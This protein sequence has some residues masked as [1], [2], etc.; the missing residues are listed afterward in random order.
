MVDSQRLVHVPRWVR[1]AALTLLIGTLA[2][3]VVLTLH[4]VKIDDPANPKFTDWVLVGMSLVH[5]TL[6]GLA[7]A[8]VLFY[9]EREVDADTLSVRTDT[10]LSSSVPKALAR[11]SADYALRSQRSTVTRL[12]PSDIFGAAYEIASGPHRLRA[13]IG[14]NVSRLFVIVWIAVPDAEADAAAFAHRLRGMFEFTF[15]GARSVGYDTHFEPAAVRS[16][17][18]VSLWSTVDCK[19]NLL[20]EPSHRLFWL[21]DMAMM[22]ESFWR[23]VRRNGLVVSDLEPGPL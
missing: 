17:R 19:H 20:L 15:G 8:L 11:V 1:I 9:T 13:W 21:Q 10:V 3:A 16:Q 12:G 6:S 7:V 5:L 4:F 18:I 14:L 23:T 22:V 2:S